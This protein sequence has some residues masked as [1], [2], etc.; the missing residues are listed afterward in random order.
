MAKIINSKKSLITQ[1]INVRT[2]HIRN[3]NR[4]LLMVQ[5]SNPMVV[6]ATSKRR[7]T[8]IKKGIISLTKSRHMSKKMEILREGK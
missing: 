2:S 8:G 3:I 6:K 7:M 5:E 1:T 4:G